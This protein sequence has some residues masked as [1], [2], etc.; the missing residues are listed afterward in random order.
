M[1]ELLDLSLVE[2][3][4]AISGDAASPRDVHEASRERI[5][6]WQPILNSFTELIDAGP[7]EELSRSGALSGIPV[8][9]KDM[10]VDGGRAPT[11]GSRV[12]GRW[13]TGTATVLRRLRAAGGDVIGYTN[14][15][16]WGVDCT[17]AV[18][19][20]GPIRN[21]WAPEHIPGGSSGGSAAALACGAVPAAVG[22]DTGGSIRI[23]AACCGVVGLKPTWGRVPLDGF[24]DADSPIDHAGPMARTVTD[25]RALFEV[26]ADAPTAPVDVGALRVGVPGG[27]FFDDL[28]APVAAAL[29]EAI[30][31]LARIT[32][33]VKNVDLTGDDSMRGVASIFVPL[34]YD[35]LQRDLRERPEDFHSSTRALLLIGSGMTPS[36]RAEGESIRRRTVG[37]WDEVFSQ[38]DVVVTPTLSRTPPLVADCSATLPS[39]ASTPTIPYLALNAPMNLAGIPALSLP[40]GE[41]GRWTISMTISAARGRDDV[42][43]A[44]GEAFERALDGAFANRIAPLPGSHDRDSAEVSTG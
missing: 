14:L 4:Q 15:H 20:T 38:V 23:P 24:V 25:V 12:P 42:V 1:T 6:V 7:A 35:V 2:L 40:C 3:R 21:P 17:S 39:G 13:L 18:T 16:E 37:L 28:D 9:V 22:S 29:T 30:D 5:A 11:V 36:D 34:T 44:L 31:V 43:L 27:Y 19:A 26:L 41:H 10:F 8:A 33:G 32:R